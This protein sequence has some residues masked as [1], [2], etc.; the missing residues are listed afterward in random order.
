MS[1]RLRL[2]YLLK[3]KSFSF[4]ELNVFVVCCEIFVVFIIILLSIFM[5]LIIGKC[6]ILLRNKFFRAI[7]MTNY[8]S[9]LIIPSVQ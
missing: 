7:R 9:L 8:I 5:S 4:L 2:N 1:R 3:V 6:I